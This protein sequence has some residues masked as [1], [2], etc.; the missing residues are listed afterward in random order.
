MLICQQ[1]WKENFNGT[2]TTVFENT[3]KSVYAFG[4]FFS[5]VLLGLIAHFIRP[6]TIMCDLTNSKLSWV[7]FAE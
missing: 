3:A 5:F 1:E 2:E 6:E 7:I 4:F